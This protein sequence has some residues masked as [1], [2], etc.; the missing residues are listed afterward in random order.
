MASPL[1]VA[2]T[3]WDWQAATNVEVLCEQAVTAQAM[4][5]H[6]FWL[7]ENHFAGRHSIP[8]PLLLLAA[9]AARTTSIK[10]GCISYLLPIRNALLAAEEVAVLDQ[11][12]GG[13]LILGLGRGIQPEMFDAF[14]IDSADKR[15]LFAQT[16]ETMQRAWRGEALVDGRDGKPTTLH[17][18]P[19]QTPHPPLWVAAI[20]PKALKQVAGLGLPYLASPMEPFDKLKANYQAYNRYIDE[21]SRCP[22]TTV[23]IMRSV[24][25]CRDNQQ[26]RRI[27]TALA[28]QVPPSRRETAGDVGN[29]AIVG[30]R[31]SVE[32]QL[33]RH[34]D[35]L[36]LTH[37]I[38]R[39]G[40]RG[41]PVD[42]Q[43]DSHEQLLELASGL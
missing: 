40:V 8:A 13:R 23:P 2:T 22:V 33:Q 30:S 37:L 29:W 36:G 4:G 41:I 25:I 18:L 42:E 31:N 27:T 32:D 5:F 43:L 28:E 21:A 39:S 15:K 16:L 26:S 34:R 24:F 19:C 10:L 3:P 1:Q 38:V 9:V 35:D 11:L 12:S 20:G 7:P 14:G 6:S 17:P